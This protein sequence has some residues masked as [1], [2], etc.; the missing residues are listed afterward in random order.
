M[1]LCISDFKKAVPIKPPEYKVTANKSWTFTFECDV[2]NATQDVD[3]I[4]LVT[5]STNHTEPEISHDHDNTT[6][7]YSPKLTASEYTCI[8]IIQIHRHLEG[9]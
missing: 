9:V 3:N 2:T 4:T 5:K 7:L 6:C 8:N 1:I